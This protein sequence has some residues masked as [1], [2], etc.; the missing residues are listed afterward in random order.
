L[1]IADD[2]SR[3]SETTLLGALRARPTFR[4]SPTILCSP[5][6]W[7]SLASHLGPRANAQIA[8]SN[9]MQMQKKHNSIQNDCAILT[10]VSE[11]KDVTYHHNGVRLFYRW[12]TA[13]VMLAL[14]NILRLFE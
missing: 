7:R 6:R 9:I 3:Y 10:V 5:N 2:V 8:L 11:T 12:I 13:F 1:Y 4:L 14:A